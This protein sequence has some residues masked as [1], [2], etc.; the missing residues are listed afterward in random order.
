MHFGDVGDVVELPIAAAATLVSR[1][2]AVAIDTRAIE[3]ATMPITEVE[4]ATAATLVQKSK[5]K[6]TK[7]RRR[8]KNG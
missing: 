5:R 1:G 2:S 4:T 7:K 6:Q 3:T 8:A